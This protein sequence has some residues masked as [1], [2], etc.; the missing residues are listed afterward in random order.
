MLLNF[1]VLNRPLPEGLGGFDYVTL[2][3]LS[4]KFL[5]NTSTSLIT[6]KK[7][8]RGINIWLVINTG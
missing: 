5:Q 7:I 3:R 4:A 2:S 8:H 1:T 6:D